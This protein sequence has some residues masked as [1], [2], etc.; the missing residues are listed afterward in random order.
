M[1]TG[2]EDYNLFRAIEG[3]EIRLKAI[4]REDGFNTSPRVQVGAV[5]MDKIADGDWPTLAFEMGDIAP[6]SD[7]TLSG[8]G[9]I[10]STGEL[11][12]EWPC[13]VWGYVRT[14]EDKRALYR[15]G[16]A[17]LADVHATI[18]D[19]ETLPDGDGQGSVLMVLPRETV[20]DMESF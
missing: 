14:T 1:P 20:F 5:V 13:Y 10:S 19:A 15:A 7:S 11:R 17:L 12:F 18:F 3:M 8:T 16:T 2:V 9:S 4:S 6:I